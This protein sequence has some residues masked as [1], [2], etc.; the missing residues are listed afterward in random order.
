MAAANSR[1]LLAGAAG[2]P[3]RAPITM[4]RISTYVFLRLVYA[5]LF[6]LFTLI[7]V[8]QTLTYVLTLI[9]EHYINLIQHVKLKHVY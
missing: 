8:A 1:L 5:I 4:T 9:H 3:R 6:S 2:A 7:V